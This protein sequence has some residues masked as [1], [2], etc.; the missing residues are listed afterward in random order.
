MDFTTE[1]PFDV[2]VAAFWLVEGRRSIFK[3]AESVTY[4]CADTFYCA[5]SAFYP[6]DY[7]SR[8]HRME[9]IASLWSGETVH[10]DCWS[11]QV[12][13]LPNSYRGKS[14]AVGGRRELEHFLGYGEPKHR[15]VSVEKRPG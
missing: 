12:I 2:V 15:Q 1:T 6:A 13:L 3:R 9:I 14:G 10:L 7:D 4:G 8:E 5:L 11:L